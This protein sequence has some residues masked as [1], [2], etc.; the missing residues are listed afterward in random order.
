MNHLNDYEARYEKNRKEFEKLV[1]LLSEDKSLSCVADTN[2][3]RSELLSILSI[4][5]SL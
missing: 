3:S 2:F 5:Y 1:T 4:K